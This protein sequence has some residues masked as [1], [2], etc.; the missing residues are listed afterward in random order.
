MMPGSLKIVAD[1]G[2]PFLNGVFEPYA[3]I[4]FKEGADI[5]RAD[6]ADADALIIRTR[7][8]CDR[9]LLKDSRVSMIATATIGM[10]HIDLGYCAVNGIEVHNAKGCNAGGVM[11]YV[12]SALYGVC[13]HNGIN[14]SGKVF[15][16]IGAGNVGG[17]VERM[18]RYLGFEVLVCDPPRAE[19]E[20]PE[21]FVD[22][23]TLLSESDIVTIHTP[24]D[25]STREM[26][27]E[28]FFCR[29]KL[30]AIFINAARGE[31]V[32]D[33]ALLRA[34][35][36][37]GALILDTW[38]NEPFVNR[39]LLEIA[40]IATPHIAGYSYQ[41]KMNRTAMAVQ[42]VARR[43]GIYNLYDFYPRELPC[44]VPQ[45][46]ELS[47]LSQGEIAATFQYNYPVFADDFIFRMNPDDF[48]KIR[49]NYNYRRE[50]Y[51]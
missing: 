38:N 19:K 27:D 47:G 1:S 25:D 45:K 24:L 39:N 15:G 10:D 23:D 31:V 12:F 13:A 30:G 44:D 42:A 32:N 14:L 4:V 29:M 9:E 11:Q 2:I 51:I 18:A 46:L 48:E 37:L 22:L 40:D 8:K 41:G 6:V 5:G 36:K 20:G 33:E 7:T 3:D 49:N 17:R 35:P 21:G 26:A 50:I 16:I 34:A 28:A 43:F